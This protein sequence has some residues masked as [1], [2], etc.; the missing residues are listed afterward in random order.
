MGIRKIKINKSFDADRYAHIDTGEMLICEDN[1]G[2]KIKNTQ[3]SGY[4]TIKSSDFYSGDSVCIKY[5]SLVLTTSDLGY[6]LKLLLTPKTDYNILYHNNNIPH[7]NETLQK[8]LGFKS[9]SMYSKFMNKL[10][11]EGVLRKDKDIVNGKNRTT[12]VMNPF[13]GR[14]RKMFKE[15]IFVGFDN[16]EKKY[17][18]KRMEIYKRSK[19]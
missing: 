18:E 9:A 14:K 8:Y 13:A 3:D 11:K 15:L 19:R 1:A 12:Y 7:T 10:I 4:V 6:L 17:I 16:F 5:L 2:L